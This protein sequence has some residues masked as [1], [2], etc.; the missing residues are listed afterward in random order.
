MLDEA[1]ISAVKMTRTIANHY[2]M[3]HYIDLH[4]QQTQNWHIE[5]IQSLSRD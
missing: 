4:E 5:L 1:Y 2:I 3:P